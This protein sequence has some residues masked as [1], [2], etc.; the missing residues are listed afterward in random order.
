VCTPGLNNKLRRRGKVSPSIIRSLRLYIQHQ[1]HVIYVLW[2]L[3][4]KQPQNMYDINLMLY[5]QSRTPDDGQRDRP[6]HV[7]CCSKI[8]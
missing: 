4:S 2:V 1:V 7:E 5:V 8:K 6:K 3:D